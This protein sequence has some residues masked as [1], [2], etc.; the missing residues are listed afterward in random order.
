MKQT[1]KPGLIIILIGLFAW[2][3]TSC[4]KDD[5]AVNVPPG[6]SILEEAGYVSS[7]TSIPAGGEI[8][9]KL[10]L[11]KGDLN[12]TNFI[13][14]VYT[15]GA[16]QTYFDTGMNVA[17]NYE[18]HGKFVKSLAPQ[19]EWIFIVRDRD[20]NAG[21]ASLM[22]TL[23]TNSGYQTLT[24]YSPLIFGAQDNAQIGGCY[25]LATNTM[26][27]HSI[28]AADTS[29]QRGIDMMCFYDSEDKNTIASPG[30][31][32]PDGIFP[33][34]PADWTIVNTTR[35]F[36]TALTA[37]DYNAAVNDS[38]VIANYDEGTA[39]RKAKNLSGGEV[40]TF[41]T[42]Q[43]KLGIFMVNE[44][45]GTNEGSINISLKVQP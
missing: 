14:D 39:K 40:Y 4:K 2:L 11:Q 27:S 18:W 15:D 31:N 20:G 29:I 22:I 45:N 12:I 36:E 24:S 5:E 6:I 26:Y 34:N 44:V 37:D 9:L 43:G 10:R 1:I 38:I 35:Y 42:Q 28:A 25:F 41:R 16:V 23:D 13:I 8:N 3:G 21:T 19:E 33:V 32:L 7:D 17:S 30:A